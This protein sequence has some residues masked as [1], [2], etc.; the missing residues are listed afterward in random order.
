VN[1][2]QNHTPLNPGEPIFG[3]VTQFLPGREGQIGLRIE[4]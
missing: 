2:N 3:T 1:L 4:F